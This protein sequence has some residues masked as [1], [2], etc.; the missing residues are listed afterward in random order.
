MKHEAETPPFVIQLMELADGRPSPHAGRYLEEYVPRPLAIRDRT[1]WHDAS[2]IVSTPHPREARQFAS[3]ADAA[4][5]WRTSVGFRPDGQ[6][7]RP[8]T[9][10]SC[11]FLPLH[12]ALA[13]AEKAR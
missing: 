13:D 9:A 11:M 3:F 8:L 10:F 4:E 1:H 7:N 6:P 12:K 5:C 2:T